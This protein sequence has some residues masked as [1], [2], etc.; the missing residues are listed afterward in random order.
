MLLTCEWKVPEDGFPMTSSPPESYVRLA[1]TSNRRQGVPTLR[2]GLE[3][4]SM[5]RLRMSHRPWRGVHVLA[6]AGWVL[7]LVHGMRGT[8]SATVWG[9]ALNFGAIAAVIG[10]VVAR[11][12]VLARSKLLTASPKRQKEP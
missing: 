6:S 4:T 11:F 5:L 7:G 1:R 12:G 2:L 8:D 10:A 3:L 9:E